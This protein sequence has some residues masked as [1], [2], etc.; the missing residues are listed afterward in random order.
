M[1]RSKLA[2]FLLAAALLTLN[3]GDGRTTA[4]VD[5]HRLQGAW[6]VAS[7][8]RDGAQDALQDGASLTFAGNRVI[9]QP[10]VVQPVENLYV[11]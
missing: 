1:R 4:T 6:I 11:S 2:A 9:F 10:K 7:V 3:G 5:A 8:H